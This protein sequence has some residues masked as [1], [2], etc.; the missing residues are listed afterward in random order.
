V[1]P[2]LE[3]AVPAP[4]RNRKIK[5]MQF[6]GP[7]PNLLNQ[8]LWGWGQAFPVVT[9]AAQSPGRLVKTQI[10]GSYPQSF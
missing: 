3:L 10:A 5:R 9:S 8:K 2:E 4:L 7:A 1:V 6:L